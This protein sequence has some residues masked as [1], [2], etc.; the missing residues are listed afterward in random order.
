MR[1]EIAVK[2]VNK[3]KTLK[4]SKWPYLFSVP[5]LVAYVLF[6][7]FPMI[8]SFYLSLFDWNGIAEKTFIGFGNY[9]KLFSNDKLFIKALTNTVI[10]M[11]ISLPA[12]LCGGLVIAFM[13]FNLKRGRRLF[14]VVNFL[15]YI[16]TPVAIGFIFSYIFDWNNGIL[17]GILTYTGIL[18]QNYFW[19]QNPWSARL[20]VALMII[21]RNFG[22]C[23]MIYLSGMT[24]ISQ[25]VYEAAKI[26]GVSR[27][28]SFIYITV[29]LLKRITAFLFITALVGGFQMFDEPVQLYSGWSAA[30]KNIGGPEYAV[31]TVIWKFYDNS[32]GSSTRLGYGASMAYVLFIIIAIFSLIS[33]YATTGKEAKR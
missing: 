14:Q 8:Y 2:G 4:Q 29:P 5:F 31:L 33:Y 30:S 1:K 18:E 15:P 16:T 22:Y 10:I 32:F 17:N 28:Q 20:I 13:L 6:L 25:D 11:G 19:L 27:F 7:I 23:M 26:D 9:I 3:R 21:W 12:T 24:A